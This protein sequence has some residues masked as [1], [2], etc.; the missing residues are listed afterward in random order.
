MFDKLEKHH[1]G[2]VVPLSA[3]EKIEKAFNKKFHF[4]SI[5]KTTDRKFKP[6]TTCKW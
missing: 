1:L 4:D 6:T 2:F 3:R 5:Q